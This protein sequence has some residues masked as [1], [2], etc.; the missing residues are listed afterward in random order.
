MQHAYFKRK[1]RIDDII[2]ITRAMV[3]MNCETDEFR[4]VRKFCNLSVYG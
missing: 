4:V 2:T 1:L 3:S